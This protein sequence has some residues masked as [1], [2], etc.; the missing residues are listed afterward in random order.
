MRIKREL[1]PVYHH[2]CVAARTFLKVDG[3][4]AMKMVVKCFEQTRLGVGLNSAFNLAA[5]YRRKVRFVQRFWLHRN[6]AQIMLFKLY[7]ETQVQELLKKH[8]YFSAV[9]KEEFYGRNMVQ[10]L[11]WQYLKDSAG[12][13]KQLF[14]AH[15]NKLEEIE[16]VKNLNVEL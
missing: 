4:A 11:C 5:G 7:L 9:V 6:D 15:R 3:L 12:R 2:L 14:E 1:V 16:D 13:T 8:P 10:N